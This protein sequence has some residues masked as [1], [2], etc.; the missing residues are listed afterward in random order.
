MTLTTPQLLLGGQAWHQ[1][2][3][4]ARQ[5]FGG[6]NV[7]AKGKEVDGSVLIADSGP[8]RA[9]INYLYYNPQFADDQPAPLAAPPSAPAQRVSFRG[10]PSVMLRCQSCWILGRSWQGRGRCEE[11]RRYADAGARPD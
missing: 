4:A 5:Q 10:W 7:S 1:L 3:L 9:D 8:W 6:V 11:R 2:E